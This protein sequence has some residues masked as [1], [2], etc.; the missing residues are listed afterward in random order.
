MKIHTVVGIALFAGGAVSV[1]AQTQTSTETTTTR[2]EMKPV[3]ING[4]VVRYEPGRVI[5]IRSRDKGEVSYTLMPSLTVPSDVQVGRTVTLYTEPGEDGAT[6]VKRVTTT[7]ITPSGSV[8]RTTEET[9][10]SPSGERTTETT[11]T[12]SG[13]VQAFE[14]SKSITITRAD[15]TKVT[16]MINDE[17]QLPTGVAVGRRVTIY[18]STVTSGSEPMVRRV[19]YTTTSKTKTNKHGETKTKTETHHN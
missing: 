3:I 14:P 17:S 2:T 13:T 15:G 7:S 10:T 16:Y 12:V 19:V 11:T 9:R 8:K 6:L 4:E 18:P 1:A 5:V